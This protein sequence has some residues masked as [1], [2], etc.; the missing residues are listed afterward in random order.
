MA[1]CRHWSCR[2]GKPSR[3]SRIFFPLPKGLP[4][5]PATKPQDGRTTTVDRDKIAMAIMG[6]LALF[7]LFV[8][9]AIGS[10]SKWG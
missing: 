10:M 8:A 5:L 1:V 4:R 2:L 7:A 6:G 3:P 9:L